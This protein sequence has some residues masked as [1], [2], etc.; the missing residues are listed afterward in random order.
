MVVYY[1]DYLDDNRK[2]LEALRIVWV[3]MYVYSDPD[4]IVRKRKNALRQNLSPRIADLENRQ[5]SQSGIE[6]ASVYEHKSVQINCLGTDDGELHRYAHYRHPQRH[7]RNR[8]CRP[9]LYGNCNRTGYP[10]RNSVYASGMVY[11]LPN[12]HNDRKTA[13]AFI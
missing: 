12:G 7:L 8:K 2:H 4:C 5:G 11:L 3:C 10:V 1:Y 6:K 9:D 13:E